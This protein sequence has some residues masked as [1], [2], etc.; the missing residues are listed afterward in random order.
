MLFTP[1]CL[2]LMVDRNGKVIKVDIFAFKLCSR[3]NMAINQQ[4]KYNDMETGEGGRDG[5]REREAVKR[6]SL[7]KNKNRGRDKRRDRKGT[8]RVTKEEEMD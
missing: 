4:L 2:S 6:A 8:R 5:Q 3:K 7:H 1:P